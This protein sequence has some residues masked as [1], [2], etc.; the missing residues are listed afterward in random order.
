MIMKEW[1]LNNQK[2]YYIFKKESWLQKKYYHFGL[3]KESQ[4]SMPIVT[5]TGKVISQEFI[6]Q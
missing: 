1:S 3:E 5:A 2:L 6:Q 4:I